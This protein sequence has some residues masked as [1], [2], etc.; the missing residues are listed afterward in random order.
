[1][2]A[3]R[4]YSVS[5]VCVRACVRACVCVCVKISSLKPLGQLKPNIM[6]NPHGIGEESLFRWS[7]SFVVPHYCQP[8]GSGVF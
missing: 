5:D 8:P 7:R 3:R 1:M 2:Y 4:G 6:W